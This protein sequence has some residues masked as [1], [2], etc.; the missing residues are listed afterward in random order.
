MVELIQTA[1]NLRIAL[2]LLAQ[3]LVASVDYESAKVVDSGGLTGHQL[4]NDM[5]YWLA[6]RQESSAEAQ[7]LR[8]QFPQRCSESY[9]SDCYGGGSGGAFSASV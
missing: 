5:Q 3:Y 4:L 1:C 2:W 6:F 7:P 9:R 8:R